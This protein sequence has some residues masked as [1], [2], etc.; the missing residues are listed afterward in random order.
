MPI[1]IKDL[2][3]KDPLQWRLLNEGVSSNNATDASTLRYELETFVCEG[4]YRAGMERI[5]RGY[6]DCLGQEQKAAWVSGFYG[7]GKSHLVKVLRYLWTDYQFDDSERARNLCRVSDEIQ[8]FLKELSTRGKQGAGLHSAGGTLKAGVGSVRLRL[9]AIILESAGFSEKLSVARLMMDLRDD[10]KL[11]AVQ[12]AIRKAG[13]EPD[14]EF[15]KLYT[16]RALQQA[17][18]DTHPHFETLKNVSEALRAQYP[19]KVAGRVY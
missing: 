6:L 12:K 9:L 2:F 13:K 3:A 4:E 10:D 19:A 7:S 11:A 17:Y 15:D 18:L 5:L 8:D 1:L 16:S 14:D